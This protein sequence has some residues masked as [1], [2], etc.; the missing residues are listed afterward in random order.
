MKFPAATIDGLA[1]RLLLIRPDVSTAKGRAITVAYRLDTQLGQGRTGIEERRPRRATPLLTQTC[2]LLVAAATADDWRQ[3]LAALGSKPVAI[4]LWIDALPVARWGERIHSAQKV[5]NFDP[6]TDAFQIYDGGSIPGTPPHPLLAPLLVGRWLKRPTAEVITR[7]VADAIEVKIEEASPWAMRIGINSHGTTWAAQPNRA[8]PVRETSDYDLDLIR[9]SVA[10]EPGLDRTNL[11]AQWTQEGDFLFGSRLEIRQ[12]LTFFAARRG[13]W[14][15]WSPV[16]AWFT[17]GADT[18]ATP[19][20]YTAR[21]ASDTLTLDYRSGAVATAR[22]GFVQEI[23]VPGRSQALPGETHLYALSYDHDA[24]NPELFTAWDAPLAGVEGTF[25][26]AQI[27]H[28]EIIRSLKPQDVKADLSVAFVAGSLL[29]DYDLQRL[30]GPLRLKIWKCDPDDVADTRTLL[31][32]GQVT[33]VLPE[34]NV[35]K[36]TAKLFGDILAKRLASWV[37]GPRCNTVVFSSLCGLAEGD[38]DSSGTIVPASL[39]SDGLTLTV[40]SVTGWGGPSYADNW[41]AGGLLRTGT[42]RA[43]MI[44][45]IMTS[46]LSG[47]DLVL[48]L[49]RPLWADKIAGGGQSV[50]LL[51]GCDRQAGTCQTKFS[52]FA[53]TAAGKG[54]RGLPYIPDYLETRDAGSPQK[55]GK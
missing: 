43:T 35:Y 17:P 28:Q 55:Q 12:H 52:N 4:P 21:F 18:T 54:F 6:V 10:R 23:D 9:L 48:T 20:N 47:S 40:P 46:E 49:K 16:P 30:Y 45:T 38:H 3:G 44:V 8:Q 26:P 22:L 39:S 7:H 29:H 41:F 32:S 24:A 14:E 50:T 27:A 11:A 36:V 31:F 1:V 13:A 34:G 53:P 42:G 33:N 51:P 37:Y 15:S 19:H 25:L 2:T 5:I